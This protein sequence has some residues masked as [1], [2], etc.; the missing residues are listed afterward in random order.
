MLL[1]LPTRALLDLVTRTSS[2]EL[3]PARIVFNTACAS[4]GQQGHPR[5]D[6]PDWHGCHLHHPHHGVLGDK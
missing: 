5:E 3:V 2:F 6:R 4:L 1:Q